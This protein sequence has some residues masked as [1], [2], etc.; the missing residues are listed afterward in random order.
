MHI[1]ESRTRPADPGAG[2]GAD[3]DVTSPAP[4]A[5]NAVPGAGSSER[6]TRVTS[7]VELCN[8]QPAG[9]SDRLRTGA[10][11][12]TRRLRR[13][14]RRL[15]RDAAARQRRPGPLHR[16]RRRRSR[17]GRLIRVLRH[18]ASAAVAARA[19]AESRRPGL[20]RPARHD[21]EPGSAES[22]R[23]RRAWRARAGWVARVMC[24][25]MVKSL[26]NLNF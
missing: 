26:K 10:A 12:S 18:R 8:P 5:S 6:N 7:G 13:S 23:E 17:H 2:R 21:G 25:M 16:P 3:H 11:A 24:P 15:F 20:R 1:H 14:L 19:K 9:R 22:S 4:I